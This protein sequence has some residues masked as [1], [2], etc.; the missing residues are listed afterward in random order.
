M[1]VPWL[2]IAAKFSLLSWLCDYTRGLSTEHGTS[3]LQTASPQGP[4][5]GTSGATKRV[6]HG[7]SILH[8]CTG[9]VG[10]SVGASVGEAVG[11]SVHLA[12]AT[13]HW[14]ALSFRPSHASRDSRHWAAVEPNG[15]G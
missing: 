3:V 2:S 9:H 12:V 10:A 7:T 11:A 8:V 6:R 4:V 14:H 13:T 15:A 1:Q 5:C